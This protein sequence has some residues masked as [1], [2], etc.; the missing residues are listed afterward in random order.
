L[1]APD[2]GLSKEDMID[3]CRSNGNDVTSD[4]IKDVVKRLIGAEEAERHEGLL[5]VGRRLRQH[6]QQTDKI[7]GSLFGKS[8]GTLLDDE[9]VPNEKH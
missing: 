8:S 4:Q 7:T 1:A 2:T 6:V 5:Y 3:Y 9:D